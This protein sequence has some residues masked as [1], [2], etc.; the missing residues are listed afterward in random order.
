M[1]H[2][3]GLGVDPTDGILY[4]ASHY[5][6]F[7]VKGGEG[8]RVADR[9]QDTMG[10]T[11]VGPGRF[12]GSGHPDLSED[13]PPLLGLIES[14]DAAETWEP[15]SLL[16]EADLH[17]IEAVGD[18]TYALDAATQSLIV[19]TDRQR[20]NSILSAPFLDIAANPADPETVY[21][22][23]GNGGLV[24]SV[25]QAA[26][27][28]VDASPTLSVIDWQP[29]GPLVGVTPSGAVMVS[30]DG[31]TQWS[32]EGRLDGPAEALDVTSGRW[33]AATATGV[34]ESTDDGETWKLVLE[35]DG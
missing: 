5:G 13:L 21:A 2:V 34:F 7:R 15:V 1:G 26:P 35:G 10:F 9:W 31:E 24:R 20:W 23:T 25:D 8:Q 6:V 33:H 3:H 12:L 11:V 27:A 17:A 32:E 16:G 30:A 29:D 28:P 4:V 18:Y 14:T 22:T 19:T